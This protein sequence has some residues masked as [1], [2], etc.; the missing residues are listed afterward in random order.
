MIK[1][2]RRSHNRVQL[3]G[4]KKYPAKPANRDNQGYFVKLAKSGH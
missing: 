2:N 1:K 4:K 3:E